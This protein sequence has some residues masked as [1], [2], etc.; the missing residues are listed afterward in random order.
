MMALP[1]MTL[2]QGNALKGIYVSEKQG[3]ID[4]PAVKAG[5]DLS[6]VYVQATVAATTT[7]TRCAVNLEQARKAGFKVGA[8]HVYDRHF[9]AQGQMEHFQA[10]VKGKQ[11]DLAPI[12][13]IIPDKPYDINI[14]RV[15][16][17][18][19]MMEKAYKVK[20]IIYASAE[21]YLK[22]FNLERYAGYA[23]YIV[24]NQ[25]VF[26]ATRYTLWQYTDREQVKG[27][28]EYT[29]AFKL[30]PTYTLKDVER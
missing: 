16:M 22:Y 3:T 27:I 1:L 20:P 4:W 10:A 8:V 30:H 24:S 11:M 12:V 28:L 21:T 29:P 2:G 9:S 15:D 5:N 17:L 26:P 19:N 6:M 25:L 23:V 7:D 14:K 18:L 13:C